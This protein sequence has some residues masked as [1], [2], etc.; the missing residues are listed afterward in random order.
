MCAFYQAIETEAAI[1]GGPNSCHIV[2][3]ALC[4]PH[5]AEDPNN[6]KSHVM[7]LDSDAFC[8]CQQ[9]VHQ[10]HKEGI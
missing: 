8:D 10:Y 2:P 1:H 4:N 3:R 6:M 7:V 9:E 5:E